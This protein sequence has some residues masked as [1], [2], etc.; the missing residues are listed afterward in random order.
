[1]A[2]ATRRVCTRRSRPRSGC[3]FSEENQTLATI[4]LQ[5]YFRMYEKLSGM[6]GTAV[7]EDKE[8]REIYKLPVMVIPTNRPMIRDD[9]NDLVYRT[10]E[11]KFDAVTED[12]IERTEKG[13]PSLVG[14]ISIENSERLSRL[15]KKRG[16]AHSV[17]NAKFH[18]QEA[19]IIAQAGRLGSVTIATNMAGR[20]TDIIL[21]GNP[22]FL[23]EDLA[24]EKGIKPE[25]ATDEQREEALAEAKRIC[26]AEHVA[27]VEA[28][29]PGRHR[30][31]A[32]RVAANRQ[33]ASRP[34]GTPGRPGR[35]PVLPV[36]RGRPH[37]AVRRRSDGSHLR[38]HGEDADSRRHAHPGGT[39]L[40]GRSRAR[41]TRSRR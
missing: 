29:R 4:T 17:L 18:E 24:R 33:P 12:I 5:N 26:A 13:Q 28:G 40:Q 30:N 32:A 25:E 38:V 16:I 15:L 11:A 39:R 27:V 2:G 7:T 23:W 14:T 20:G 22:E 41:S 1:M 6:T 21:G 19:H 9:R 35:V 10:V 31:R 36:A 37:A 34:I 8:F 3:T